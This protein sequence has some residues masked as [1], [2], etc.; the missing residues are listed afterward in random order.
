MFTQQQNMVLL[1]HSLE[2][3][4]NT[5]SDLNFESEFSYRWMQL[6]FSR[7]VATYYE[8]YIYLM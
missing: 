6:K 1:I 2:S 4:V 7:T 3:K 5:C 8:K